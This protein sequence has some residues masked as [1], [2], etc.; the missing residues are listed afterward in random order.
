MLGLE[1]LHRIII[2]V[3]IIVIIINIINIIIFSRISVL[4]T[5]PKR[6]HFAGHRLYSLHYPLFKKIYVFLS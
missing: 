3:I 2:V 5:A 4:L 1:S 6:F